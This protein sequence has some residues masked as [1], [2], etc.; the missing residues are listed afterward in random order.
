[1]T[2]DPVVVELIRR[3]IAVVIGPYKD[4]LEYV[5]LQIYYR[6]ATYDVQTFFYDNGDIKELDDIPGE[7]RCCIDGVEIDYVGPMMKRVVTYKL[8]N[9][10]AA[11]QTLYRVATGYEPESSKA[12]PAET[13]QRLAEIYQDAC[14]SQKGFRG[15]KR[16]VTVSIE[17]DGRPRVRRVGQSKAVAAEFSSP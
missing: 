2:R 10:D 9:R 6:R 4:R 13:R 1:M 16:K 12:L 11:L 17:E 8:P 14:K 7:W 5:A 3:F 15:I